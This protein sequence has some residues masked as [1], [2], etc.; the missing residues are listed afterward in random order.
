[1]IP[2]SAH[3][4]SICRR[5]SPELL[6][7]A[8]ILAPV[9]HA[10]ILT[11]FVQAHPGVARMLARISLSTSNLD[12]ARVAPNRGI[13]SRTPCTSSCLERFP[14]RGQPPGSQSTT[15]R[16]CLSVGSCLLTSSSRALRSRSR[17]NGVMSSVTNASVSSM[18]IFMRRIVLRSAT[19]SG[20]TRRDYWVAA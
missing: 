20:L 15:R 8:R 1:M 19:R 12:G 3:A 11:R 6:K 5:S 2:A 16:S 9:G 4:L 17:S 7:C 18:R 13:P 14:L 10:G